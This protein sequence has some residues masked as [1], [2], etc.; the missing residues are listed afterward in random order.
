M[1]LM[2][3]RSAR[4]SLKRGAWLISFF[5]MKLFQ[6]ANHNKI[7]QSAFYPHSFGCARARVVR[8]TLFALSG[9]L[10]RGSARSAC[11]PFKSG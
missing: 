8:Q 11:S 6:T 4:H 9:V 2:L 3:A 10:Q 1:Q 5:Q 7:R